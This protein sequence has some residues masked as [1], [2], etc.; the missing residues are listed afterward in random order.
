MMKA[1]AIYG[2]VISTELLPALEVFPVN[3]C[4]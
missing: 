1:N 2:F 4:K 3:E